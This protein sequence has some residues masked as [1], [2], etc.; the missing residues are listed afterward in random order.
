[1]KERNELKAGLFIL[2]SIALILALIVGI[3]GLGRFLEPYQTRVVEFTIADNIGGLRPGDDVRVGGLKLGTV[4]D[5]DYSSNASGQAIVVKFTLPRRIEMREGARVMVESTVTGASNLN[6]DRLGDGP[7]LAADAVLRG[8]PASLTTLLASLGEAGPQV[9]G[10][11]GDIRNTSVPKVNATVDEYKGL[12]TDLRAKIEPAY[13][14]YTVVAERG[15]QALG[16][17]RDVFGE[18]KGDFR[19]TI[20][21]L[22]A[23]TT[24]V[25]ER[26]GPILEK[27]DAGLVK[28][29]ESIDKAN[30]ALDDVKG[31]AENTR[32]IT[33]NVRGILNNNR[34]RIESIIASV[35]ATA[36]NLKGA[37]SEI[38]RSP[39]RVL[40]RPSGADAANQSLFDAAR[41]FADGANDL[42]DASTALRDALKNPAIDPAQVQ[43]LVE[44]LEVSFEK[45]NRVEQE[46]WTKVKD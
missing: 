46:L 9:N 22:A 24:T 21:N 32:D 28:A 13:Q 2:I 26:I 5:V 12:A 6:V 38:R 36:D 40:Y 31:I 20:A 41:R 23:S 43:T 37:T 17:I 30:D 3:K 10:L 34:G 33:G 11:I 35:K 7:V 18:T 29:Q 44:K 25:K 27:L 19:T 15:E 1:M 14:K 42:E 45:F 16:N 8:S 4:T 39:W